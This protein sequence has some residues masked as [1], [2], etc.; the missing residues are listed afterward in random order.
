MARGK[1]FFW[2]KRG[3]RRTGSS[4]AGAAT[5]GIFFAIFFLGGCIALGILLVTGAL[6]EWR[7]NQKFVESTC[8]VLDASLEEHPTDPAQARTSVK[9]HHGVGSRHYTLVITEDLA[10]TYSSDL[11]ALQE[12]VKSLKSARRIT[13]WYEPRNPRHVVLQRGYTWSTWLMLLF[14]V[15][16]V[17]VGGG[18]LAYIV[19]NWGKSAERRAVL[20]QRTS[21]LETLTDP[22]V[23][24]TKYPNVPGDAELTSSRGTTLA[25]RLAS[26]SPAWN[27]LAFL[28]ACLAWNG[29]LS[30]FVT[31]AV[32]SH[33][34]GEPEWFLTFFSIP[35]ALVGLILVYGFVRHLLLTT[36]IAPAIVE[37]SEHP[38]FPGRSYDVFIAQS[39]P[40]DVVSFW[41]LMVCEEEATFRQGTNS[42]TMTRRVYQQELLHRLD[43]SIEPGAPFEA[44]CRVQLPDCA[45]HSFMADHNKIQW[46]VVIQGESARWP[47]FERGY[48]VHV[49]PSD[50]GRTRG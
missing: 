11:E 6:P 37:I 40:L 18:G 23:P 50:V 46:K 27:L 21:R 7:V 45:M 2:K 15:P 31:V 17:A 43:F 19:M 35:L 29:I 41:V 3:A 28:L 24:E 47:K 10:G 16:F 1:W 38:L 20:A 34:E 30:I 5:L 48:A 12:R 42:R 32:K 39:G 22:T 4:K 25:F 33:F 44:L 13:C 49:Y 9:I 14:P 26:Q 36:V 8:D